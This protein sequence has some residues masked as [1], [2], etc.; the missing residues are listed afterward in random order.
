MNFKIY[1]LFLFGAFLLGYTLCWSQ[2]KEIDSLKAALPLAD[3][4]SKAEI[5]LKLS[6]AWWQ[7]DLSIAAQY[8]SSAS[9]IAASHNDN[10]IHI[11]SLQALASVNHMLGE[12]EEAEAYWHESLQLSNNLPK[13]SNTFTLN[14]YLGLSQVYVAQHR[15]GKSLEALGKAEVLSSERNTPSPQV[16]TF[17]HFGT[18]Y[19]A[20]Y[21]QTKQ[22]SDIDSVQYYY[23][24]AYRLAEKTE[25][26][27]LRVGTM[28]KLASAYAEADKRPIGL[29]YL[30]RA[31]SLLD[32]KGDEQHLKEDLLAQI[33]NLYRT[34]KQFKLALQ[35]YHQS[36]ELS[37]EHNQTI[38]TCWALHQMGILFET[39]GEPEKAIEYYQKSLGTAREI[40]MKSWVLNNYEKLI[41]IYK[42]QEK[43]EQA[44]QLL[45]AFSSL[46]DSLSDESRKRQLAEMETSLELMENRKEI[47]LL[48]EK[49]KVQT[50]TLKRQENGVI[51]LIV[52]SVIFIAVILIL[53]QLFRLKRKTNTRLSLKNKEIEMQSN[54]LTQA[55]QNLSLLSEM[56]KSIASKLTVEEIVDTVYANIQSLME[57]SSFGIGV[58]DTENNVLH[59]PGAIEEG[60]IL[61][62]ISFSLDE[63]ERLAVRCFNNREEILINNFERD[64]QKYFDRR[65]PS[66]T[67]NDSRSIIYVP[68]CSESSNSG[69][70]T[71]QSFN[72]NA[73]NDYHLYILRNLA[74]YARIAL[75]NAQ[76]YKEVAEGRKE[77][78][79]A[80]EK[81]ALQ[82]KELLT[83][84]KDKNQLIGILAHDLRN[85]ISAAM[86]FINYIDSEAKDLTRDQ[87]KAVKGTVRSLNRMNAM[88]EKILD[89]RAIESRKVRM[90]ITRINLMRL[91]V[92]VQETFKDAAEKKNQ[93]LNLIFTSK[94][95]YIKADW[96]YTAQVFENLISN[97]VKFSKPDKSITIQLKDEDEH[98]IASIRDEGPG[99]S[100]EEQLKLFTAFQKLSARPTGGENSTGLGL[101]IVKKYVEA[102][103]GKVWC[104]SEPGKGT[105]F[106][107]AFKK[108][109]E[110][111]S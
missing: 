66:K 35:Y 91:L 10:N 96:N 109:E 31:I 52:G 75:E 24:K 111:A 46:K 58:Y 9:E 26:V 76:V 108:H 12:Q 59:F 53:Y 105:S 34:D 43:F 67:T 13:N 15:Y 54:A 21:A 98:V 94:K 4:N 64:Y 20:K 99:I 19:Y 7:T 51:L 40:G 100:P 56:G 32:E 60:H 49:N 95:L 103:N 30:R 107:V 44:F 101:A 23:T 87:Q 33:G 8:A 70:M 89:L 48:T 62:N 45:S 85:P 78:E 14:A 84:N 37:E 71:V 68:L 90:E 1:K 97:A 81:I 38:K 22:R 93:K 110:D 5:L 79:E 41:G 80:N 50:L 77:L 83:L 102:M 57:A 6:H 74:V 36:L 73:Y 106:L 72:D 65:L 86:T 25:D 69:V 63:T 55:Y 61:E 17:T 82:N 16:E 11:K 88:I 18:H 28:R 3:D 29:D 47:D 42:Q 27:P 92:Q 39:I 104:E 2:S